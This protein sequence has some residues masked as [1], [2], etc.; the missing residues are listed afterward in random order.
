MLSIIIITR[1]TR[2][3][4]QSLLHSIK[5][6]VSLTPYIEDIIVIDNASTDGTD[7]MVKEKFP[8]VTC[9]KNTKNRG[10]AASAN[11][12]IS[13]AHGDYV[14]FLNSD[15]C[16]M[17]GEIV[18]MLEFMEKHNDVGIC[19][20]QLVFPDMS[21]QRSFAI[22]P[23]LYSEL[24]PKTLK[25]TTHQSPLTTHGAIDVPSLIGAAILVRRSVLDELNGFDERFFFFLEETDLCVRARSKGHRVVYFPGAQVIHLQGKT[26]GKDWVKGRI[27]YNISIHKFIRKHHSLPYYLFFQ[28][29]RFIKTVFFL[30]ITTCLPFL[31]LSKRIRRSYNYYSRLLL[32]SLSGYPD[33]SGLRQ[34]NRET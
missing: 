1:N 34:K 28:W 26:V 6:D 29:V 22:V 30:I 16:L 13:Y 18:K 11:M 21:H 5:R 10:F 4:L 32:W 17:E 27:E 7:I 15:T 31:F 9:V 3:L 14:L 20:P 24:I 8:S 19:G 33:T 12:G 25:V 2:E 23:S